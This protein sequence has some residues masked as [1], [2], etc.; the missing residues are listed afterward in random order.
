[1]PWGVV[2]LEIGEMVVKFPAAGDL[3][4]Q[5]QCTTWTDKAWDRYFNTNCQLFGASGECVL[6][7]RYLKLVKYDAAVPAQLSEP[8]PRQPYKQI[9]W[10]PA[11]IGEEALVTKPEDNANVA[12][13]QS[14]TDSTLGAA[15]ASSCFQKAFDVD[16]FDKIVVDDASGSMLASASAKSWD[17][18][19]KVLTSGKPVVWVTRG[20]NQGDSVAG[21]IPQGFLRVVRSEHVS[22]RIALVDADVQVPLEQL[23]SL[24]QH[25]L[26]S[27]ET[28]DSGED[29]EFWLT[30]DSKVLV[31]RI[32]QNENLN[33]LFHREQPYQ[34]VVAS[35][36]EP[37]K[38]KIV[39]N[40]ILFETQPSPQQL[41]P[42]EVDILVS[43]AE[44]SKDDLSPH[45]ASEKARIVI[46]TV[47]RIGEGVDT[48]LNGRTVAAY[49][50][51]AFTTRLITKI[52]SQINTDEL[53]AATA[54]TLP[55]LCKAV[56][57]VLHAANAKAGDHVLLLPA[58]E[59]FQHAVSRLGQNGAPN[60][61]VAGAPHALIG[62]VWRSM[63]RGSKLLFSDAAINGPLDP[64]PFAR[65]AT[66]AVCGIANA[67]ENDDGSALSRALDTSV[68]L[69]AET[70]SPFA[71][72]TAV[73]PP[74][75][76]V[77]ELLDV[78]GARD[79]LAES[80]A[81][82]LA[83]GYGRSQIKARNPASRNFVFISRSGTRKAE[84]TDIVQ[85]LKAEG[86]SV[87]V[88]CADASD[89][90]A[91][92]DVVAEV[93]A[94]R[95]IRGVIHAAMVLQ[96]GLFQEMTFDKYQAALKPKMWGAIALHRALGDTPLD[97][98]IMTSS[99][100][101]V[102][103]NP[104]QAN[105]CAGNSYLDFLALYRRRRGQAACSLALPMV[106]DVGVVAENSDIADSLARKN[107]FGVDE[108][109]ML[110]AFEAAMIQ[111]W[112][113]NEEGLVGIGDAQL[114]L[115]L[116]PR[117]MAVAMGESAD[118]SDAY[119]LHDARLAPVRT[120]LDAIAADPGSQQKQDSA[121][122]FLASLA[123]KPEE[124]VL[125][126][127]G[128]HIAGRTARI[129]GAQADGFKLDEA[130]V[131][132]Y[133]VDSMIGVELQSWLFKEFAL[134][135]SVQVL[136]NPNTTF[137]SLARLIVEKL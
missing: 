58:A 15:L 116:E 103:G 114:V 39:E 45:F 85:R 57:A 16:Q 96:D 98:F 127:L 3:N 22:A 132:S 9:V 43:H 123:G 125:A 95:P 60:I 26:S 69:L 28:K 80:G 104:G 2:P 97:F 10:E 137:T 76:D 82:V 122:A 70:G 42:G 17:L 115:G 40:E 99:L 111:G 124:E 12:V 90:K 51:A 64:R 4:A 100:S 56:D 24:V 121:G 91:V 105:Y 110:L 27:V 1:M 38:G 79:S 49:T 14:N 53:A 102:T 107:P 89:E 33:I 73:S 55:Y 52:F 84:A 50:K 133:G 134:Q 131:A 13:L 87:G 120:E 71:P 68:A 72:A 5:G 30:Q 36:D 35:P 136:S 92:A 34:S 86:A 41:A 78:S 29:V 7:I 113:G 119:W 11:S 109:E 93:A 62:E 106:E 94:T 59:A 112:P 135:I 32:H 74:V 46:G 21:G 61:V 101:A 67:D 37:L 88:F 128:A 20:V 108:R 81:N 129:L 126:A 75:L 8:K 23:A 66:L 77:E 31:P 6:D 47:V 63:P 25:Q 130:S 48:S 117:E 65:G 54:S 44:L 83:I 18:V 19:K 118:M